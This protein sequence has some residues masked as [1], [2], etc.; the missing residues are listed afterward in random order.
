MAKALCNVRSET[1]LSDSMA[2]GLDRQS[3]GEIVTGRVVETRVSV[4][5]RAVD[6][7][8]LVPWEST[9]LLVRWELHVLTFLSHSSRPMMAWLPVKAILRYARED[10]RRYRD[11]EACSGKEARHRPLM[12]CSGLRYVSRMLGSPHVLRCSPVGVSLV[13]WKLQ[14]RFHICLR[15]SVRDQPYPDMHRN[16]DSSSSDSSDTDSV[17]SRDRVSQPSLGVA[18]RARILQPI[19]VEEAMNHGSRHQQ[20]AGSEYTYAS[21]AEYAYR[22]SGSETSSMA[23]SVTSRRTG[24]TYTP[25]LTGSVSTVRSSQH[26]ISTG[27]APSSLFARNVLGESETGVLERP[28]V[29]GPLICEFHYLGCGSTFDNLQEWDTHS[30]THFH[31]VS[32]PRSVDCPF[33]GCEWSVSAETGSVAWRSRQA[34]IGYTHRFGGH[35]IDAT[36][37]APRSLIQHLWRERKIDPEQVQQLRMTGRLEENRVYVQNNGRISDGRRQR[38][39]RH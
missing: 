18:L 1:S 12:K 14:V 19:T 3:C 25:S 36:R 4:F 15:V 27:S 5:R 8:M 2:R 34:H 33:G 28:D 16:T 23:R 13:T 17:T 20:L 26:S 11:A 24:S 30:E 37:V 10:V 7:K 39:D 38:R 35:Q 9:L 21:P 29:P 32:L 6:E 31:G 22:R